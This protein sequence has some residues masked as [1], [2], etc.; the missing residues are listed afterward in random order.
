MIFFGILFS[1]AENKERILILFFSLPRRTKG[2]SLMILDF[3]LYGECS[4]NGHKNG[5]KSKRAR[6]II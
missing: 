6:G 5:P 4:R 3:K 1:K 2:G